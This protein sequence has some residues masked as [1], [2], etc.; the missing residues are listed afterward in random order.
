MDAKDVMSKLELAIINKQHSHPS[1]EER[2]ARMFYKILQTDPY[3]MDEVQTILNSLDKRYSNDVK[4]V[5]ENIADVIRML[6][7]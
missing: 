2:V 1:D 6:K 4:E 3:G 5:I 7:D